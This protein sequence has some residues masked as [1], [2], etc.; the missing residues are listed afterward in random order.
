MWSVST[1]GCA[2]RWAPC[3]ASPDTIRS[4]PSRMNGSR[5][6][7][8]TSVRCA[9][10]GCTL[11]TTHSAVD[12]ELVDRV[13]G[14]DRRDVAAAQHQRDATRRRRPP[15][16]RHRA[17]QVV[18]REP[19]LH[20][21][22]GG[23]PDVGEPV[24]EVGR[25]DARRDLAVGAGAPRGP[26]SAA[27]PCARCPR[28]RR[29]GAGRC[30]ARRTG[31]AMAS[32]AASRPWGRRPRGSSRGPSSARSAARSPGAS[33]RAGR[34]RGRI[35]PRPAIRGGPELRDGGVAG[36]ERGRGGDRQPRRVGV[37]ARRQREG[38][39]RCGEGH[40]AP[41]MRRSPP[42]SRGRASPGCTAWRGTGRGRWGLSP[43]SPRA[44]TRSTGASASRSQADELADERRPRRPGSTMS[45]RNRSIAPAWVRTC[46]NASASPELRAPCS[47]GGRATGARRPG[48]A[49][50]SSIRRIVSVPPGSST[51]ALGRGVAGGVVGRA[52]SGS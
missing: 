52:A 13:Q 43:C 14:P 2:T 32:S 33:R 48:R 31:P 47:P 8:T 20:P 44:R 15:R 40:R 10:T 16:R 18:E 42:G 46:A 30:A 12:D 50:S 35:G 34:G 29:D 26:G 5:A 36:V 9:I 45:L 28:A 6:A 22:L 25:H 17:R 27:G 37:W 24:D 7:A 21:D 38:G 4:T 1:S 51:G 23:Q 39:R 11:S 3:A 41:I 19:A 49:G